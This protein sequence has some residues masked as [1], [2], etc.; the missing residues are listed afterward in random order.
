MIGAV[1]DCK[2]SHV[3]WA[4]LQHK[5]RQAHAHTRGD[6]HTY[7]HGAGSSHCGTQMH[8]GKEREQRA[9]S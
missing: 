9:D 8:R 2:L 4:A 6:A 3:P 5:H 1:L 7:T